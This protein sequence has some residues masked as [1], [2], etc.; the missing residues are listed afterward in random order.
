MKLFKNGRKLKLIHRGSKDS[1][2]KNKFHQNVDGNGPYVF[3]IKSGVYIFGGC[4]D[5]LIP[6][7]RFHKGNGNSFIFNLKKNKK[8]SIFKNIDTLREF[9]SVIDFSED[10]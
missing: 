1:L 2:N 8:F 10:E 4:T 9:E 5:I 7:S 6:T 3:L